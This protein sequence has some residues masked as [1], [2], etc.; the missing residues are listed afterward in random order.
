[1]ATVPVG[2]A[3]IIASI[4][5]ALSLSVVS[6]EIVSV[7][8]N[9]RVGLNEPSTNGMALAASSPRV[10]FSAARSPGPASGAVEADED[11]FDCENGCKCRSEYR[12]KNRDGIPEYYTI[13][14]SCD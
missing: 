1:M 12:G 8:V 3:A 5:G 14:V 4:L 11:T 6:L 2:A 10:N 13:P 7:H 9:V